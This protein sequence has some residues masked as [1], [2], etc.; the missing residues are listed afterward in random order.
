MT[1]NF[2][3]CL[4]KLMPPKTV[5]PNKSAMTPSSQVPSSSLQ[6][7]SPILAIGDSIIKHIEPRKLCKERIIKSTFPGKTANKIRNETIN[8][9]LRNMYFVPL[10]VAIRDRSVS[11]APFKFICKCQQKPIS[12]SRCYIYTRNINTC[13]I[14]L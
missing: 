2:G 9:L 4:V 8:K 11:I 13:N 7:K 6:S 14:N 1:L 10:Y 3:K 5:N 12:E